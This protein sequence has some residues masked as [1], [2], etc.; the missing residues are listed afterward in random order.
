MKV[1]HI[2]NSFNVLKKLNFETFDHMI[3]FYKIYMIV[4]KNKPQ[5]ISLCEYENLNITLNF[6][7]K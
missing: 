7:F 1:H 4:K 2:Q 3:H 5:K 6:F